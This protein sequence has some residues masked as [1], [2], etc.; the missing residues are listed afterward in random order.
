[1]RALKLKIALQ[2]KENREATGGGNAGKLRRYLDEP[3][4]K[5]KVKN[6]T[7]ASLKDVA[8]KA[9]IPTMLDTD[10]SLLRFDEY[11][12]KVKKFPHQLAVLKNH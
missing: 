6:L 3:L 11:T 12:K 8:I 7:F 10:V 1:M 9:G 4:L 2:F 5:I